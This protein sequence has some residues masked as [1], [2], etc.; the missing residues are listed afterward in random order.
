MTADIEFQYRMA[1]VSFG[2][3]LEK[4][5]YGAIRS[6]LSEMIFRAQPK[7]EGL[8]LWLKAQTL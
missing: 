7:I 2:R 4:S 5:Q 1:T 8:W 3:K 6:L